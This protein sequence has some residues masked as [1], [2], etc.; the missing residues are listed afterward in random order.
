[1]ARVA[2]ALVVPIEG[3]LGDL[4]HIRAHWAPWVVAG[5]CDGQLR[6]A[7]SSLGIHTI[8]DLDL[9]LAVPLGHVLDRSR[10]FT[11]SRDVISVSRC[12]VSLGRSCREGRVARGV[13][14]V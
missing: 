2:F 9:D 4:G 5:R 1:M 3:D 6:R 14:E 13:A 7:C 11:H 10:D 8:A 12:A